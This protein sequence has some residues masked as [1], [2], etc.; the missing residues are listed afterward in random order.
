M[1][2]NGVCVSLLM[3]WSVLRSCNSLENADTM[4]QLYERIESNFFENYLGELSDMRE[5]FFPSAAA[6]HYWRTDNVQLIDIDVC[7]TVE[8]ISSVYPCASLKGQGG[9]NN[10]T[11]CWVFRWTNSNLLNLIDVKQ[12]YLFEP[13]TTSALFGTIAKGFGKR[14]IKI[15]LELQCD[16]LLNSIDSNV[17]EEYLIRFLSWVRYSY[18][19]SHKAHMETTI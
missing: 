9:I 14:L 12:L 18:Y 17:I 3:V 6:S 15:S 2:K 19:Q 7:L 5:T 8:K 4:S 16:K 1:A 13:V 10:E 11:K